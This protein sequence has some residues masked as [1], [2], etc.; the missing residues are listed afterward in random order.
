MIACSPRG[1]LDGCVASI[2]ARNRYDLGARYETEL[3]ARETTFRATVHNVTNRSYWSP[4]TGGYLIRGNPRSVWL[5]MAT[6]F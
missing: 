1:P 3:F 5:P 4:A 2:P 6:D